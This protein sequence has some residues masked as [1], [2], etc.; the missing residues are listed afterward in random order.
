MSEETAIY[1]DV[2]VAIC[3]NLFIN[4]LG[5]VQR[6]GKVINLENVK[7]CGYECPACGHNDKGA[8]RPTKASTIFGKGVTS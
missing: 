6:S 5:Q 8:W 7:A 1:K 3:N 4:T 2:A